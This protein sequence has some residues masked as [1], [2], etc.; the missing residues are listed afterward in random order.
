MNEWMNGWMNNQKTVTGFKGHATIVW[1][2]YHFS[3]EA[4]Q[5]GYMSDMVWGYSKGLDL[6]AEPPGIKFCWL[7]PGNGDSNNES[8]RLIDV[9]LQVENNN[10]AALFARISCFSIEAFYKNT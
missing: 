7:P 10:F 1:K 8:F 4:I 2:G 9:N 3:M 6:R 5:K